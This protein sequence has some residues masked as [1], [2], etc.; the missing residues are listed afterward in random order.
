MVTRGESASS[1]TTSCPIQQMQFGEI[2]RYLQGGYDS[3]VQRA[4]SNHVKYC[5]TCAEELERIKALRK[6]G[7]HVVFGH[8][9]Q[10]EDHED[11]ATSGP[12]MMPLLLFWRSTSSNKQ[13][14]TKM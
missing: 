5:N 6:V 12:L 4:I 13:N 14:Q 1:N 9:L 10:E 11:T 2:V 7:L 3:P 8:L